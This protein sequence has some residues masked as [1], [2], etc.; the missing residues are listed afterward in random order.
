M[1]RFTIRD[2]LWAMVVVGMGCV[3]TENVID[4]RSMQ[5]Q[6]DT[7]NSAIERHDRNEM[8]FKRE[9]KRLTGRKVSGW[10][11]WVDQSAPNGLGSSIDYENDP[12]PAAPPTGS[13]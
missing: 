11:A 2:V 7:L 3:I 4:R 5:E 9:L 1:F 12:E 6:I 8:V 10:T 13:R